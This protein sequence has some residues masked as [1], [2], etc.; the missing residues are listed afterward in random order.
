MNI[1]LAFLNNP[2]SRPRRRL[3][4]IRGIII[5]WT[6]NEDVGA[7][8]F[9]NRNY[10]NTNDRGA[11][12]HYVVDGQEIVQCI[13]N[14]EVAHHAG[15]NRRALGLPLRKKLLKGNLGDNPND[16]T[17]G[18]EMC[19]NADS[20]WV[21]TYQNTITLV[22]MLL[23]KHELNVTQVY[24]HYDITGKDC[25]KMFVDRPENWQLF[26]YHL[27]EGFQKEVIVEKEVVKKEWR[28]IDRPLNSYSIASLFFG[29]V[30]KLFSFA[31]FKK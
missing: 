10:F 28:E 26:R 15:D 17:I 19:V 12:A 7:G 4:E 1:R 18:I 3:K 31:W 13:P 6:A 29:L 2:K 5:H 25:P 27:H 9:A 14:I 20:S 24:R 8:A 21:K 11:S 16:Y 22:R 23:K 30:I